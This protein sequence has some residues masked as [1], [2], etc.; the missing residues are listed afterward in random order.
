[1]KT[2]VRLST[3]FL[4]TQNAHQVGMLVSLA[5]ETPARRA[6]INV[7][8]VLDRSGSMSRHAARGGQG[9]RRP[10]SPAFLGA[11]GPALGRGVRRGGAHDLR[12]GRGRRP[13]AGRSHRAGPA[14]RLHQPLRRLAQG[15]EA[16]R[17][18]HGRRHQPRRP[19]HRRPGQ[20]RHRRARASW[21][22]WRGTAPRRRSPPPASAS[23]RA[24]TRTCSSRWPARAA[25]TTGTS[26]T[27]TRWPGS[28]RARSRASSP[29]PRRTSRSRYGSPTRAWPGVSFL[30]S[31]PV[32]QTGDGGWRSQLHDLYATSPQ[33]LALLFHVEDVR[34]LGKVPLGEIRVE[35]DVVPDG[36]HRAPHDRHAGRRQP[37][38][39]GPGRAHRRADL[40]AVPGRA[41]ARGGGAPGRRRRLR[42]R[43]GLPA[44]R[45]RALAACADAPGIAEEIDDL[46]AEAAQLQQ[47]RYDE[48]DRKYQGAR[49]MAA[50]DLKASYAQRVSRQGRKR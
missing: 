10:A 13:G 33:A 32:A 5:G 15:P 48:A 40:P 21:S 19:P 22:A 12:P 11:R 25:A 18:G 7:A 1:M 8:L 4:T 50:R 9:G 38:R 14:R 28:S 39:R 23:A 3:R 49:A 16:G 43:G 29:S 45:G 44:R 34:E 20:R 17:E 27:T 30:Q 2:D 31:Y 47:R 42:L 36:R 41:R 46:R 37:R 6:P 26:S 24:S 35:A